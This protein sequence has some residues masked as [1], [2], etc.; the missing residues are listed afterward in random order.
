MF[1]IVLKLETW[2]SYSSDLFTIK[3]MF[4][5]KHFS[6]FAREAALYL[7]V[8]KKWCCMANTWGVYDLWLILEILCTCFVSSLAIVDLRFGTVIFCVVY[9]L[10]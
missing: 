2:P 3:C 10:V 6:K 1:Q 4:V 9:L 5:L 7:K 8:H